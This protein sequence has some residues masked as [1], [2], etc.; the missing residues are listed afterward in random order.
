MTPS[1]RSSPIRAV[2]HFLAFIVVCATMPFF[3][4]V[5]RVFVRDP[6]E[7]RLLTVHWT[8]YWCAMLGSILGYRVSTDGPKPPAKCLIAPNHIGY[9]DIFA[10]GSVARCWFVPKI[11][12]SKAPL[13]GWVIGLSEQ[14]VVTR[15]KARDLVITRDAITDRLERGGAVCGFFEG[16]STAGDRVLPFV[17]AL[18]DAAITTNSPVVPAAIL[19]TARQPGVELGEDLAYWRPEHDMGPHLIRQLGLWGFHAHVRFGQPVDPKLFPHRRDLAAEVHARTVE[20]YRALRAEAGLPP[21]AETMGH[22]AALIPV[23]S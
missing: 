14:V 21:L 10:I 15:N 23:E 18:F 1:A 17:A 2:T 3:Y 8:H 20:L 13:I 9:C 16:T 22:D 4:F 12:V 7:R 19:W 6:R 11:E 5:R